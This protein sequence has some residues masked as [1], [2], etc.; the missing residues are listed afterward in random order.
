MKIEEILDLEP[1]ELMKLN[2]RELSKIV[3]QMSGVANKRIKRLKKSGVPSKALSN[4]SRGGTFG[5]KDKNINQL[6]AEFKRARGFL[7]SKSSTVRGAKK[8]N[9]DMAKSIG[10]ELAPQQLKDFWT[11]YNRLYEIEPNFVREYGST[12]IQQFLRNELVENGYDVDELVFRGIDRINELYE[13]A[14]NEDEDYYNDLGE[15]FEL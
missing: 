12:Q 4:I 1:G 5:V 13:N 10:G 8:V 3:S 9:A 15:F 2:K 14:M 7:K 11:A 6:R